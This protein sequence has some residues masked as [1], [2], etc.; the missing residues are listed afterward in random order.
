MKGIT[1]Q[2]AITLV[3]LVYVII[4]CLWYGGLLG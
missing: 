3:T 4:G 1:N 2:E